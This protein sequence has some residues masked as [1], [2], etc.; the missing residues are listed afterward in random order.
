MITQPEQLHRWEGHITRL[1]SLLSRRVF[2]NSI[3]HVF[4]DEAHC[5][6]SDGM[7][8]YGL[9]PFRR[10]WSELGELRIKLKKDTSFHA[11]SGTLPPHILRTV[12]KTLLMDDDR[13]LFLN[14][15]KNRPNTIYWMH[16][17]DG[18]L[19]DF[20]H[21][22][23]VVPSGTDALAIASMHQVLIFYDSKDGVAKLAEY[24]DDNLEVSLRN[25]GIIRHYHS[26]MSQQYLVET[27]EQFR[28]G[29][30][31]VLVATNGAS[32]VIY[33][34]YAYLHSHIS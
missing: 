15:P 1:G 7:P 28:K 13:L 8:H 29:E 4:V 9:P 24:L 31:K 27:F 21:L 18:S 30:C 33:T 3:Q 32:T 26:E 6:Y 20:S 25:R 17:I 14:L 11:L 2:R 34:N 19:T 16:P 5:I 23:F 12:K 22:D 10:A